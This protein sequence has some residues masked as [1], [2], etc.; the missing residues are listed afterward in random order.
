[1]KNNLTNTDV[2]D[3]V[4]DEISKFAQK[5]LEAKLTEILK[6]PTSKYRKELVEII[7]KA[8]TSVHKF[9]YIR[10]D[11]WGNDVK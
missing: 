5:E 3:I 1:M 8:I 9:M 2:K 7:K 4:R 6:S 10:K 11:V